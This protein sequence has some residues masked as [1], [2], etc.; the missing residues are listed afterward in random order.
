MRR[1][2]FLT[3][4]AKNRNIWCEGVQRIAIM[5]RL[6][7]MMARERLLSRLIIGWFGEK[8]SALWD[9]SASSLVKE[10]CELRIVDGSQM[11]AICCRWS[12]DSR[13][14]QCWCSWVTRMQGRVRLVS[15][16]LWQRTA[17]VEIPNC[18]RMPMTS[19]SGVPLEKTEW[20]ARILSV[21]KCF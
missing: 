16:L 9:Q 7:V 15:C 3:L 1:P 18:S 5:I 10:I 4:L 12:M 19:R 21:E 8:R 11:C 17:L 2:I 13:T 14:R 6:A 20:I